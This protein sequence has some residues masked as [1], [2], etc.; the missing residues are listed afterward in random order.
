MEVH[1][2]VEVINPTSGVRVS[3]SAAPESLEYAGRMH[4]TQL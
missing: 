1:L 4:D 3:I 2:R